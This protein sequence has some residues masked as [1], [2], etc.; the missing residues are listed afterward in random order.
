MAN[1][2]NQSTTDSFVEFKITI[3]HAGPWKFSMQN[4]SL[5]L[6]I[7][8]ADPEILKGGGGRRNFLQK[9]GGGGQTTYS[10]AICIA[11]KQ[12]LLKKGGGGG[13]GGGSCLWQ[14]PFAQFWLWLTL[15]LSSLYS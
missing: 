4:R 13:G 15:S 14:T 10:G 3:G 5:V 12:N 8:G 1:T 11:N 7:A 6:A 2:Y 9:G